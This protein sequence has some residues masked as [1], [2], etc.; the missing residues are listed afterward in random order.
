MPW[1]ALSKW[2]AFLRADNSADHNC[3]LDSFRS[4]TQRCRTS[5]P[6][7]LEEAVLTLAW[8]RRRK[9][10]RASA[11]LLPREL[12]LL[13]SAS[14]SE[15]YRISWA[16]WDTTARETALT[17]S[18]WRRLC[19]PRR[20]KR[21]SWAALVLSLRKAVLFLTARIYW[22]PCLRRWVISRWSLIAFF[23]V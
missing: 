5:A 8:Q 13:L 4:P 2:V 6:P 10:S 21:R 22:V 20:R 17:W 18:S 15:S 7:S 3:G 23:A 14:R 12:V 1:A 11:P 16:R 19:S 9:A